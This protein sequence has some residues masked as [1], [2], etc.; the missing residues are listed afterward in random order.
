MVNK[1]A[2]NMSDSTIAGAK[3]NARI[4]G[5]LVAAKYQLD[6]T[7][8]RKMAYIVP[9]KSFRQVSSK[10]IPLAG[11]GKLTMSIM[12]IYGISETYQ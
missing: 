4:F 10:F 11:T 6:T 2:K 1:T 8:G 5:L 7:R 9:R 12:M 3:F